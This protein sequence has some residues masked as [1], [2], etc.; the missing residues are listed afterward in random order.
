MQLEEAMLPEFDYNAAQFVQ[1]SVENS[2]HDKVG[3][4]AD[5]VTRG[6]VLEFVIPE[7]VDYTALHES[8]LELSVKVTKEKGVATDFAAAQN[9]DKVCVANNFAHTI[10]KS[11][12]IWINGEEAEELQNYPYRAY[13]D[14]LTSLRH[15]AL[16]FRSALVCWQKDN[17]EKF[18]TY[19]YADD[20]GGMKERTE[21]FKNSARVPLMLRL[22]TDLMMQGLCLPPKSKIKIRVV[23]HDDAFS[24]IAAA[25]K[26]YEVHILD[27]NLWVSR[28]KLNP[29]LMLAHTKYFEKQKHLLFPSHRVAVKHFP[30][31]PGIQ[32]K[33]L[34]DLFDEP[35]P[36]R[37]LVGFL[38]NESFVGTTFNANPFYFQHFNVKK[39]QAKIGD[40]NI[41]NVAYTPNFAQNDYI[42][43]YYSLL[44]EF[45]CD[46]GDNTLC[47]SKQEFASGYT[48]F[49]FR[50]VERSR[51]GDLVG[52]PICG[53]A[54]LDLE[55]HQPLTDT[56]NVILYYETRGVF[57]IPK[58][59]IE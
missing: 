37:F 1:C 23:P 47:I 54:S 38:S 52:L 25:G 5:K 56:V 2:Y 15:D 6:S 14:T 46:E 22:H 39:L 16:K 20:A 30:L 45:N 13:L 28:L 55:F 11:V 44:E 18:T 4:T 49:P 8:R 3:P 24:L 43:E 40:R 48:L 35:L 53:S 12:T 57:K 17:K 32:K 58:P 34:T 19:E 10:I 27:A 31:A 51:G 59:K 50:L 42:R 21:L 29:N 33:N 41:P 36:D 7:S 26:K 9:P